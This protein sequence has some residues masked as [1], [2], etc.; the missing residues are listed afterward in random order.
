[1]FVRL[2][3]RNRARS[4]Q[5]PGHLFWQC[6]TWRQKPVNLRATNFADWFSRVGLDDHR[7]TKKKNFRLDF[8]VV[9]S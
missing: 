9:E 4:L 6:C 2:T 3:N 7:G 8:L 5:A 1:M